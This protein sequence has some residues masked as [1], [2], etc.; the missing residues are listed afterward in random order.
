MDSQVILRL[1]IP[2]KDFDFLLDNIRRH[3][4]P[5]AVDL[6]IPLGNDAWEFGWEP[7]GTGAK[8][9]NKKEENRLIPLE[10]ITFHYEFLNTQ[11]ELDSETKRFVFEETDSSSKTLKEILVKLE[12]FEAR[13]REFDKLLKPLP[14]MIAVFGIAYAIGQWFK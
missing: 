4:I 1:W 13:K 14:W 10:S 6:E 7:D 8:W 11:I 5:K 2:D 3:N 12:G 9:L